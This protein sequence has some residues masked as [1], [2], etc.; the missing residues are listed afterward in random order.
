M[1]QISLA[2]GWH[3][4]VERGPDWLFVRPRHSPASALGAPSL[5]EQVWAL[6][7]RN[8]T[9][10]LVLELEDVEYLDSHLIGEL[11]RLEQRIVSHDGMMRICGLSSGNQDLLR[12]CELDGR[13]PGFRDREEAVM[14][15]RPA[16]PR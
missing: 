12:Q 3:L 15:P 11:V 14:G 6:L 7:E 16:Q 2:R 9:H 1:V 4:E 13:F 5:E 8:F 10:R